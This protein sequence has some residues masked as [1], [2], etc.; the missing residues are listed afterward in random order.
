MVSARPWNGNINYHSLVLNAI[1]RGAVDVLDVGCGDGTLSADLIRA[2]VPHVA[3]L[4]V[5]ADVLSR[6]RSRHVG[7]PVEWVQGDFFALVPPEN[8]LFDAVVSVASLH[9]FDAKA[10]LTRFSELVRPG[11]VVA[12]I[13]LAA[14]DW[15]DLPLEVL[16][17]CARVGAKVIGKYW[18]HSAPTVW[19]PPLT[20]RE[21]RRVASNVLPGVKYRRHFFSRYSLVW[22]RPT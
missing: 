7:L 21:V 6:A 15:W 20:Y 12:V 16:P 8:R 1:P 13:G 17:H 10:A 9:H 4:D 3:A 19:P 14:N 22:S 18:E 2:G 5:D 11:G